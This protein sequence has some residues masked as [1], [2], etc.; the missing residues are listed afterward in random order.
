MLNVQSSGVIV[1]D[2]IAERLSCLPQ[3]N[4]AFDRI[5]VVSCTAAALAFITAA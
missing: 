3:L 4:K 1:P 2:S 5:Q